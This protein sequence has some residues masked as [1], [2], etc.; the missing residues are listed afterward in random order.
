MDSDEE[1]PVLEVKDTGKAFAYW[2][3][4]PFVKPELRQQ[5][6]SANAIIVPAEQIRDIAGPVFPQGTESLWLYLQKQQ[7]QDVRFEICVSDEDYREYAFH[8][9]LLIVA[10]MVAE[11]IAAP[12]AV[13]FLYDYIKEK[14]KKRR[15]DSLEVSVE[16]T[17]VLADGTAKS[18]R[19]RGPADGLKNF[20]DTVNEVSRSATAVA[21]PAPVPKLASPKKLNPKNKGTKKKVKTKKK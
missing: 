4:R 19:Y 14:V 10:G 6:S 17:V 3:D 16:F 18:I 21:L 8:G 2:F 7:S 15:D 13:S 20:V 9:L 1:K 11:Y 12:M 5:L